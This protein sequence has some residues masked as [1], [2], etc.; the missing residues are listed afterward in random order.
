MDGQRP[1]RICVMGPDASVIGRWFDN[2]VAPKRGIA[3]RE[4]VSM[5]DIIGLWRDKHEGG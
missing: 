3:A 4:E 1:P 2:R 5:P